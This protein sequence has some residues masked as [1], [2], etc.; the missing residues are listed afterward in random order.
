MKVIVVLFSIASMSGQTHLLSRNDVLVKRLQEIH[1]L[2]QQATTNVERDSIARVL[3]GISEPRDLERMALLALSMTTGLAEDERIDQVYWAAFWTCATRLASR[4]D[5]ESV[6]A[7][8]LIAHRANFDAGDLL[9]MN[10]L[11]SRQRAH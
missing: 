8:D 1:T 2:T 9:I 10:D 6:M 7:L 4:S 11:R 5:P 3:R